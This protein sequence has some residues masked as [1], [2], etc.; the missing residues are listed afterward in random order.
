MK[1]T[2]IKQLFTFNKTKQ[3]YLKVVFLPYGVLVRAFVA[4]YLNGMEQ[5]PR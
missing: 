1:R 3:F 4:I 2:A 5:H